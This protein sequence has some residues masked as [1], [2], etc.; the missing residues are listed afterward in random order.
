MGKSFRLGQ[1]QIE[2]V[3]RAVYLD[4][5]E[6]QNLQPK[7]VDVLLYLVAEYPRIVSRQ[8]LI[9]KVWQGNEYVGEKAL[10][11]AIW[12]LRQSLSHNQ[13][14]EVIETI[15][16]TGYRLVVAPEAQLQDDGEPASAAGSQSSRTTRFKWL[17]LFALVIALAILWLSLSTSQPPPRQI[18]TVTTEPGLELFPAP[19]PD[20]RF[21]VYKWVAPDGQVDLFRRDLEQPQL[22]ATR[23]TYDSASEG[24]S[25]WSVDGRFLYF[26]R[27]DR[28]AERC[29]IVRMDMQS[30]EEVNITNCPVVGGYH[31]ID[32]SP[33]NATL[34]FY[35]DDD[36]SDLSGIYLL[37]INKENASPRRFSCATD[38]GYKERD[39]AFSPDG[40]YLATTRRVNQFNEN[41]YLYDLRH[42]QVRQ[43][44]SGEE[45]IVGLSWHPEGNKL[46]YG[47]QRSDTR[48]GFILDIKTNNI[49]SLDIE[50][51]SYPHFARNKPW[52]FFQHRSEEYQIAAIPLNT[53][54]NNSPFP[55][56]NSGYNHNYP[57]YSHRNKKIAYLSNES[58]HYEVWI[59]DADGNNRNQLTHLGRSARY[60]KWSHDGKR[61][62][63]LAPDEDETGDHI[64]IV[65]VATKRIQ[66]VPSP[67]KGHNRPM[68][69]ADDKRILTTVFTK[70]HADIYALS[71]ET[72][73]VQRLTFNNGRYGV[74]TDQNTLIYSTYRN[75]LW[76][77][78]LNTGERQQLID[79]QQ[80]RVRYTWTLEDDAIYY[81]EEESDHQR[82]LRYDL[83]TKTHQTLLKTPRSTFET[84]SALRLD[85][86]QQRILFT[87]TEF[88]QS[89]IKLLIDP[90][91]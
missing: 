12:H 67:F 2:P 14:S 21:L 33:D 71:L 78:N 40:N 66:T 59:A 79:E 38:C 7:F 25:V 44:T 1:Y 81:I 73:E 77:L 39:M 60:P 49:Q 43:L 17:T 26:S 28:D 41:I 82:L 32:I 72:E 42:H 68:W 90:A 83:V 76:Q 86:D 91:L 51:M 30:F 84:D 15:R 63:F 35:S 52:I 20:G 13:D 19:S 22:K 55:V 87:K 62:A 80:F 23:L 9:D 8:E 74:M 50:G 3:E 4:N 37:D 53:R 54:V 29:D 61:I 10:T 18:R 36:E 75:G 56:L 11:N 31:Y 16:K 46:A 45:D 58:G 57:D 34:A 88:P 6:K 64:Y 47:V 27:K 69:S 48:S 65:E 85:R 5:G 89:D 24:H 70:E